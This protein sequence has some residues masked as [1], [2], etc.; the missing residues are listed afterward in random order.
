VLDGTDKV[1][2]RTKGVVYD[3]RNPLLMGQ[4]CNPGQVWD[5]VT[6]VADALDI[7][8][9]G[10]VVDGG[11]EVFGLVAV[12]KLGGDSQAREGHLELVVGAT[13]QVGCRHDVVPRVGQGGD[14]HELRR[15]AR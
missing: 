8:G 10:L 5:V 12:D 4:L 6:R 13:I 2:A 11:G 1:A 15:L 3:D 14:G 9:L 7:H